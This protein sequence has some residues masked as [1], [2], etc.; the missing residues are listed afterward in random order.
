MLRSRCT[1]A[2][3]SGTPRE[4]EQ[5]GNPTA[6]PGGGTIPDTAFASTSV[7]AWPFALL[8]VAF[9]AVVAVLSP[10]IAGTKPVVAWSKM[11]PSH[12]EV[13]WQ[14]SQ[15]VGKPAVAWFGSS[16]DA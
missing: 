4:G 9:I 10:A 14:V 12:I 5:G 3:P 6:T 7:P 8:F 16:V 13:E 11:A 1:S 2:S 15:V